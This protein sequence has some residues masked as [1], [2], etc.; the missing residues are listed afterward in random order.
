MVGFSKAIDLLMYPENVGFLGNESIPQKHACP[1]MRESKPWKF[2][3]DLYGIARTLFAL[4]HSRSLS[5]SPMDIANRSG[6]WEP[7][8]PFKRFWNKSMWERVFDILLNAGPTLSHGSE[9]ESCSALLEARRELESFLES[10][11]AKRKSLRV[12]LQSQIRFIDQSS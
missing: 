8:E 12:V 11:D 6:H 10:N 4:L 3:L 7:V 1:E 5:E 2:H 9:E